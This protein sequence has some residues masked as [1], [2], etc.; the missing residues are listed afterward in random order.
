MARSR[1]WAFEW[2]SEVPRPLLGG[3]ALVDD[4]V[5]I[6]HDGQRVWALS[7][8]TG[9]LVWQKAES[10]RDNE[11]SF[12]DPSD[13]TLRRTAVLDSWMVGTTPDRSGRIYAATS[14]GAVA[15]YL[16]SNGK[17]LWETREDQVYVSPVTDGDLVV[18][19]GDRLVCALDA[20]TGRVRFR[21]EFAEPL[22]GY[23]VV[24]PGG[25]GLAV[26]DALILL[27]RQGRQAW[28][29]SSVGARWSLLAAGESVLLAGNIL[30]QVAAYSFADGRNL[31]AR[32]V[33]G[34]PVSMIEEGGMGLVS[35]RQ[36]QL[37]VLRMADGATLGSVSTNGP[38]IL[39]AASNDHVI[40]VGE[41]WIGRLA[42]ARQRGTPILSGVTREP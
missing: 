12:Y 23:P 21:K 35:T 33:S 20:E 24:G 31:W 15:A 8:S 3:P 30:G 9:R 26:E 13:G 42:A 16:G 38:V 2:A 36:G 29:V 10:R 1:A 17:T 28:R 27:D 34:S 4:E 19:R 39:M 25:I 41:G 40:V 32:S 6:G 5:L 11:L 18:V 14:R 37:L 7:Q 22:W